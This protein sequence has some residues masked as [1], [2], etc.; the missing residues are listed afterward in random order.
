VQVSRAPKA[1]ARTRLRS[2]ES[3]RT[4]QPD[5][6]KHGRSVQVGSCVFAT[7]HWNIVLAARDG[8]GTTARDAL[9]VLCQKYWFPLY[10]YVRRQG[11]GP[12]DAEDLTQG[13]FAHLLSRDFL[14]HVTQDKGRFRS[15]LLACL[16]H[17][18]TDE[19]EKDRA[20]KRGGRQ[21]CC[22]LDVSAAEARYGLERCDSRAPNTIYE[23]QWALTMLNRVL[24]ALQAEFTAADKARMFDRLE[25]FLLGDKSGE[26]YA[27][28][29]LILGTTEGAIKMT[30]HRMRQRYRE[31]FREEIAQTVAAPEEVEE[32]MRYLF[33]VIC[34]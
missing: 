24:D 4:T 33:G 7:T 9:E 5:E 32:E 26:T 31:L 28:S 25:P 11:H 13:F 17:F 22:S 14:G 15:F 12:H 20:E 21:P 2:S 16:N 10:A 34:G 27:E 29:A 1:L 6:V 19:R 18:L 23:R 8:S 3:V 30:V